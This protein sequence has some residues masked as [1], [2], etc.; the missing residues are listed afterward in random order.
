MPDAIFILI[1]GN[2][3]AGA[4]NIADT[5]ELL[6]CLITD[7]FHSARR[8]IQKCFQFYHFGIIKK[9]NPYYPSSLPH[10]FS[11]TLAP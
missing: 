10:G 6:D 3:K 9:G 7:E 11:L 8:N 5:V 1:N 2:F 4:L